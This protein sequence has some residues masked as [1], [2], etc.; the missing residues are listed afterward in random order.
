MSFDA[1][2]LASAGTEAILEAARHDQLDVMLAQ[3]ELLRRSDAEACYRFA[4]D[5][6]TAD[7]SALEDCVISYG[8]PDQCLRFARDVVGAVNSRLQARILATGSAE[9]C[10]RFAE[11]IFNADH[12]LLRQ[13]IAALNDTAVLARFNHE[14]PPGVVIWPPPESG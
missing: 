6:M 14:F 13:R 4:R 9:D 11:D 1:E 3:A 8:S 7:I 5:V 2:W 10:Y 12:E